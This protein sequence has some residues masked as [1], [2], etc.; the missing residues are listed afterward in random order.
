MLG[1]HLLGL[2]EKALPP[3]MDWESRLQTAKDLGYDYVEISIDEKDERINRL[4][5][6]EA[7]KEEL[8]AAIQKTGV[9]IPSMCLSCHRRFPYGSADPVI[10]EKAHE[11]TKQAILFCRE[12]GIRV[13]QLA[14]YDVYY[15]ESTK[16]SLQY[17]LDG[18]RSAARLAEKY[19]VMLAMEIM[20]TE[21]MSSITRYKR[22]KDAIPS[23]WF[24][25]YPDLGN[26]T[27]WGNDPR[28]ELTL[29]IH[30]IVGVHLKD[31]LAVTPTFAGQFK[32]VP[33]GE[34][35]VDFAAELR[36]LEDLGYAGPYM[37]EM[38]YAPGMDWKTYI[39]DA[40][41]YIE[42]QFRKGVLETA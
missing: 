21:L 10:R 20:D 6:N 7:Q 24:T 19:Q 15:E 13:I 26:L 2:Y 33:F 34:G 27:A 9:P 38:W 8:H 32:C 25:V 14:G 11:I 28:S 17:F 3:E 41:Q 37:M 23:P 22:Y 4:F 31:T 16:E 39:T 29:G 12:F 40:K 5:W 36:I 42:E 35:C 1:N 18:L 30:E